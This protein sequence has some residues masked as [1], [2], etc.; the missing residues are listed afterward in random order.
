MARK[1]AISV[2]QIPLWKENSRGLPMP[3]V[4]SALF[5]VGSKSERRHIPGEVIASSPGAVL[6][7][8]GEELRTDDEDVLMQVLHMVRGFS[9]NSDNGSDEGLNVSFSG[10][11]VLRDLG[12]VTSQAGYERLKASLKRLQQGSLS[13]KMGRKEFAGQLLRKFF[14]D[15]EDMKQQWHVF[16]EPEIVKLFHPTYLEINWDERVKLK[17][18]IAKWLHGFMSNQDAAEEVF[19]TEEATVMKLCGSATSSSR[20]FRQL[21]KNAL[22]EMLE[23]HVIF[24]WKIHEGLVYIARR[25]GVTINRATK[26]AL[27]SA[28]A[29]TEINLIQED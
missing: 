27:Q 3:F 1:D 14:L 18:P 4:H 6:V 13:V 12:W 7:Y 28:Q 25:P 10:H 23:K 2:T 5:C 11:K 17:K 15:D 21:L 9:F 24:D 26:A 29:N 19:V 16:V 8:S 20:K 22:D